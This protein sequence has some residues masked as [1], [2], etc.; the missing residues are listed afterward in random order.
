VKSALARK[1]CLEADV[2]DQWW[3]ETAARVLTHTADHDSQEAL[4]GGSMSVASVFS[5]AFMNFGTHGVQSGVQQIQQEFQQLG[6]DLQTGNLSAAQSDFA[7]LQQM[8]PQTSSSSATQSNNPTTQEFNQLSQ[9]LQSGNITAAQQDYTKIQ[10]DFQSASA[11]KHH[12]HH[13][14]GSSQ[15]NEISQLFQ[16]LGQELQSGNLAAAQQAYGALSQDLQTFS[17][18]SAPAT[19]QS[20]TGSTSISA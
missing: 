1:I 11:H 5:S 16:Q 2:P 7:S 20:S 17:Q 15:S 18:S 4:Q 10:Q 3:H 19:A 13:S 14:G 8:N 9:D 12:H 6:Q